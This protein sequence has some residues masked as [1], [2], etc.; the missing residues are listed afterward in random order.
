VYCQRAAIGG[1]LSSVVGRSRI[2]GEKA[3]SYPA[4][5]ISPYLLNLSLNCLPNHSLKQGAI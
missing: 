3:Y 2:R 4:I 5:L 1:V